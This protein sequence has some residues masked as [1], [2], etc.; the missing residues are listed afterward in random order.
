VRSA[1]RVT[2]QATSSTRRGNCCNTPTPRRSAS[3][4]RANPLTEAAVA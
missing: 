2:N 1:S 4:S 3:I